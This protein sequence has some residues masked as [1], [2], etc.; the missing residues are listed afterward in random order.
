MAH[1]MKH[2]HDGGGIPVVLI[3]FTASTFL[4]V[5]FALFVRNVSIWD[6]VLGKEMPST[7]SFQMTWNLPGP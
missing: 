4:D 5:L 6:Q 3:G 2:R 1:A 7:P